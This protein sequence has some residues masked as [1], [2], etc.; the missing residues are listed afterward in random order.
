MSSGKI[1]SAEKEIISIALSI[2]DSNA[3]K[4]ADDIAT[5]RENTFIV[6]A[7]GTATDR[8]QLPLTE[9]VYNDAIQATSIIKDEIPPTIDGF[10]IDLNSGVLHLTFS[11]VVANKSFN[12]TGITLYS[13]TVLPIIV[14]ELTGGTALPFTGSFVDVELTRNDLNF[15][16]LRSIEIPSLCSQKFN[17]YIAASS[18]TVTDIAGNEVIPISVGGGDEF[19]TDYFSDMS[20]PLLQSFDVISD[21]SSSAQF[22]VVL[23]FNEPV[24]E[25]GDITLVQFLSSNDTLNNDTILYNLTSAST[26]ITDEKAA[27]IT[28]SLDESDLDAL[29]ALPPILRG[30]NSTFIRLVYSAFNDIYGRPIEQSTPIEVSTLQGDY[31]PP[32]LDSWTLDLNSL[33]IET[34]IQ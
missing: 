12:F 22:T 29:I 21:L 14:L 19:A 10:V 1:T 4:L 6:V 17:C 25:S 15:L 18:M 34:D 11:E 5:S 8:E 30:V 7:N 24:E 31:V 27:D 32:E 9:I 26:I 33:S 20:P 13:S 23:H 16:K 28:I 3:I 2:T